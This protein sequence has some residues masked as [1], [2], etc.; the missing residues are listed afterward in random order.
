MLW[1]LLCLATGFGEKKIVMFLRM[2][3]VI[4]PCVVALLLTGEWRR[5]TNLDSAFTFIISFVGL[6]NVA[7]ILVNP[8][9]NPASGYVFS[10]E[11]NQPGPTMTCIGSDNVTGTVYQQNTAWKVLYSTGIAQEIFASSSIFALS[12]EP[13]P[14]GGPGQ[15]NLTILN[16]T[17]ALDGA[18]VSCLVIIS[19]AFQQIA[20]FEV[21]IYSKCIWSSEHIYIH[22]DFRGPS[23]QDSGNSQWVKGQFSYFPNWRCTLSS[24]IPNSYTHPCWQ[25]YTDLSSDTVQPSSPDIEWLTEANS[26]SY[27]LTATNSRFNGI[28]LGASN[29]TFTLIVQCKCALNI[30]RHNLYVTCC[31]DFFVQLLQW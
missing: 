23:V 12:Q 7:G 11:L 17:N 3:L 8:Y 20:S 1:P 5:K 2:I 31:A 29:G 26:G 10:Y 6:V 21:K 13:L 24:S 28:F 27:V 15:T 30:N 19:A 16:V 9:S 4:F 18:T 25:C 14:V 22:F